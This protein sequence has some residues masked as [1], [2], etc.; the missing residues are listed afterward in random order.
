MTVPLF[1]ATDL[2]DLFCSSFAHPEA[3]SAANSYNLVSIA[4]EQRALNH[5]PRAQAD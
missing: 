4:W 5:A 2:K 1:Y 3:K